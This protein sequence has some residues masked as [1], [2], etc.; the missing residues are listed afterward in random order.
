VRSPANPT[1]WWGN[2]MLLDVPPVAGEKGRWLS[3]FAD[4]E[5]QIGLTRPPGRA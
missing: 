3:R 4:A 5:V 1:F 2:F